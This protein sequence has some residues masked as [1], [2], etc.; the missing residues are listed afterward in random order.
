MQYLTNVPHFVNS[1]LIP[2]GTLVGDS[3]PYPWK[4]ANGDYLP[5]SLGL[6]AI[7]AAATAAIGAKFVTSTS[8]KTPI[9][10]K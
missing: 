8:G 7:D 6:T 1:T 3:T 10:R 2:A 4:A 9:K 5:P